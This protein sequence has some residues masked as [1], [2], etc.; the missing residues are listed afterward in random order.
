MQSKRTRQLNPLVFITLVTLASVI[1]SACFPLRLGARQPPGGDQTV[2]VT[3]EAQPLNSPRF[4]STSAPV[5]SPSPPVPGGTPDEFSA[6]T[7]GQTNTADFDAQ[8][9]T[10]WYDVLYQ[11]VRDEK[12]VPPIASRLFGYAGVALYEAVV[13][14]MPGYQSLAGQLNDLPPLPQP[15]PQAAYHWP[16]VANAALATL[17]HTLLAGASTATVRA[18][19]DL[20]R[21][22]DDQFAATVPADVMQRSIAHGQR[23]G[24]AIADW[25][26]ADGIGALD[27][28]AYTPSGGPGLWEPTPPQFAAPLQPCWGQMRPFALRERSNQC[29]PVTQPVYSEETDSQFYFEALEVYLTVEDLTADQQEIARFWSDDP[30]KTGTPPG[31]TISILTQITR[32][33]P[34]ALDAAAE[35]YARLGIAV[36][37]AF[38]SCWQT[39]FATN[40]VRPVTYIRRVIDPGWTSP[41]TTPPFP[42]YTSGHSVQTAAAATVL[43][44]LLGDSY[45]FTDDTHQALGYAPR[46]FDSFFAMAQEAAIS[47]LYGGIHYRSAIE[48][49][50]EQGRCIGQQ[51]NTL[52]F[53]P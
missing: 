26:A 39:K 14:G 42:E 38:I 21:Q 49:G 24:L 3:V 5:V 43:T 10:A 27:N 6:I 33:Q 41:I 29:Q 40:V 30:G 35:A 19:I 34:L 2:E 48:A 8:V 45:S 13:P 23:V 16:T 4:D 22:L 18:V 44:D 47:R 15:D 25:A 53:H 32:N 31:H 17:S 51:V 52:K 28:C 11:R 50:L 12:L 7:R 36:A 20:E 1:L 9:A 46:S 37:D